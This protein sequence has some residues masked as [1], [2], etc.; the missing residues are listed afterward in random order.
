MAYDS[1]CKISE[2]ITEDEPQVMLF[3]GQNCQ[4]PD[5]GTDGYRYLS[6]GAYNCGYAGCNN[7]KNI[8]NDAIDG[9][10][11]P[12]NQYVYMWNDYQKDI[13]GNNGRDPINPKSKHIDIPESSKGQSIYFCP[14][15]S[16]ISS[17]EKIRYESNTDKK[18]GDNIDIYGS[19][20]KFLMAKSEAPANDI[21]DR[22]PDTCHDQVK[23]ARIDYTCADDAVYLAGNYPDGVYG[24]GMYDPLTVNGEFDTDKYLPDPYSSKGK[25]AARNAVDTINIRRSRPWRDHL[26]ECCFQTNSNPM[27]EKLCGKFDGKSDSGRKVCKSFMSE[28][29]ANDIKFGG[30]CYD[31]CK[32]N[33]IECDNIKAGF[34]MKN[35]N[36]PFCDCINYQTRQEYI[37]YTNKYP[38]LKSYP[39]TCIYNKCRLTDQNEI[40]LTQDIIN[41]GIAAGSCPD[42]NQIINNINGNNNVFDHLSQN[43]T[44]NVTNNT[45]SGTKNSDS[46]GSGSGKGTNVPGTKYEGGNNSGDNS[47]SNNSGDNSGTSF[48]LSLKILLI[49][50]FIAVGYL[51]YGSFESPEPIQ[52]IFNPPIMRQQYI[53]PPPQ[54][55]N[56]PPQF[57]NNQN[58]TLQQLQQMQPS[59]IQP[60]QIQPSQMQPS[61]IQQ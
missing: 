60:S 61:Q 54:Y 15:G 2:L 38:V 57:V 1:R 17:I 8:W 49:F 52:R 48:P 13:F 5:N 10:W 37:D 22:L 35:P 11:V 42:V 24:P 58:V 39:R 14:S 23:S 9:L 50:V 33:P 26:R 32:S 30:K 21:F 20:S 29:N 34:C 31:L 40:F 43:I 44:K 56:Q 16:K 27:S 12:P 6:P 28:C 7:S 36:D 18:C 25:R 59:Q 4:N 3:N 41:E 53:P 51:F 55:T 47:D 45:G 19:L 46:S